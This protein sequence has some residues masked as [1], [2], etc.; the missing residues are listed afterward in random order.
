[1]KIID[2]HAHLYFDQF[3]S[4]REAII[5]DDM[6]HNVIYQVQI[7]CDEISSY[8]A[9]ELTKRYNHM[10]CMLGVHPLY[11]LDIGTNTHKYK[12]Y[13][14]YTITSNT[15][16]ELINTYDMWINSNKKHI[17]GI[18]EIGFDRYYNDS[19]ELYEAQYKSF[20]AHIPLASKH[21]L[22]ICIHTRNSTYELLQFLDMHY[23]TMPFDA[24]VHC[25]S[26]T[27]DTA[28]TLINKY[29]MMIGIG[30]VITYNTAY[31]L[32]ET[33]KKIPL[34]H[35]ITE[36]DMPYLKPEAY[37]KTHKYSQSK[38]I[39]DVIEI[40]ATL[41]NMPIEAVSEV[42]YNNAIRFLKLDNK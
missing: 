26:D 16:E 28:I 27:Y 25:F 3:H 5:D 17:V 31:E 42:L 21:Q 1:M 14:D 7:G 41:K 22:P 38:M 32:Q 18:G 39:K 10:Y 37:K 40:I 23:N 6:T 30:G 4:T 19:K 15:L 36:T 24:V 13:K 29:N 11:A 34:E 2:T 12:E 9:L 20:L 35:I 8:A 33:I